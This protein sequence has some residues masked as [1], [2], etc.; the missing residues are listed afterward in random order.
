MSPSST[1]IASQLLEFINSNHVYIDE[2]DEEFIERV[3][4]AA[5][6][7]LDGSILSKSK[8]AFERAIICFEDEY[9]IGKP[10]KLVDTILPG[11]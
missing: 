6:N 2:L 8:E 11:N 10:N 5:E 1:R 3:R 7:E 4:K 9:K